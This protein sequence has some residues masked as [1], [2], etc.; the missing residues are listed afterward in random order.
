MLTV[1]IEYYGNLQTGSIESV[2]FVNWIHNNFLFLDTTMKCCYRILL[3][4][5]YRVA[6]VSVHSDSWKPSR[7]DVF[8]CCCR[9]VGPFLL[10]KWLIGTRQSFGRMNDFYFRYNI[11]L[12]LFHSTQLSYIYRCS[13]SM[14]NCQM[15]LLEN[16]EI[17]LWYT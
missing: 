4:A 13:L 16:M 6:D 14:L 2:I 3:S 15:K 8:Q 7:L 9:I 17:I 1:F 5:W 10:H 11:F 12:F